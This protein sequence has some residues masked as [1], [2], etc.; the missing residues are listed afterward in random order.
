[1]E[2]VGRPLRSRRDARL[3][4]LFFGLRHEITLLLSIQEQRRYLQFSRLQ[5]ERI[6]GFP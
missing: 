2:L 1:M 5:L 3:A 6:A 4:S